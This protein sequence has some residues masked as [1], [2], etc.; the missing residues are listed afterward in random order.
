[1]NVKSGE[2]LVFN[3]TDDKHILGMVTAMCDCDVAKEY[4]YF[5]MAKKM[6]LPHDAMSRD[7]F[8]MQYLVDIGKFAM[9]RWVE[10]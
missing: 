4:G 9:V 2:V 3:D 1:M 6:N 8:F 10:W 5:I 7:L